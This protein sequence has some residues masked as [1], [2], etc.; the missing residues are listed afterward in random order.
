MAFQGKFRGLNVIGT[1]GVQHVYDHYPHLEFSES[2]WHYKRVNDLFLMHTV[3]D[4]DD[5][6]HIR[7]LVDARLAMAEWADWFIQFPTFSYIRVYGF[8]SDPVMLPRYPTDE[9]VFMEFLR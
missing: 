5:E 3:Q 6:L 7:I 8:S 9:V 1:L 4:L 2:E